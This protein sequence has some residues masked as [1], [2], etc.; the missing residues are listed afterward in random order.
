MIKIGDVVLPAAECKLCTIPTK[1]YP[2][3]FMSRHV[4]HSH[5]ADR[6][7]EDMTTVTQKA[8]MHRTKSVTVTD[9]PS[10]KRSRASAEIDPAA[11]L[12]R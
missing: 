3:E 12:P 9:L 4:E 2:A 6:S 10:L 8:V 1:F 5:M 7:G 11:S